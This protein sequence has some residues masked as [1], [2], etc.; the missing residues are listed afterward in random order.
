MKC[1]VMKIFVYVIVDLYEMLGYLINM[2]ILNL[3]VNG[4]WIFV[5][6]VLWYNYVFLKKYILD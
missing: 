3:S 2:L 6:M 5:V 4:F 1:F